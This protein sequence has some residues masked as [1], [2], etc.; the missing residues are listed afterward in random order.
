MNDAS[1]GALIA[2]LCFLVLLSAFFSSA[3]TAMLSLNRLRLKHL[4]KKSRGARRAAKLLQRPDRLIGLILI[5]NNAVNI[6][7]ALV[8]GIIFGRWFGTDAGIWATTILLTL[9][10]LV[11]AEVT[12]KTLAALNPER[13]AFPYSAVL[14]ILLHLSLIHI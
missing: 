13:L 9:I 12:P 6:L 11:F 1:T 7:A 5:G 3:E 4:Q 2:L 14:G 10:M 8:A